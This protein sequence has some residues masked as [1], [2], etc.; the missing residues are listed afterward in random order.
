MDGLV[1]LGA[2]HDPS[3]SILNYVAAVSLILKQ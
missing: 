3:P 2:L 1:D